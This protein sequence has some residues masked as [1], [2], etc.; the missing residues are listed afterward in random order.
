[1]RASLATIQQRDCKMPTGFTGGRMF[2]VLRYDA[3]I[4][5]SAGGVDLLT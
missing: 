3:I 2:L 1:M 4:E 5:V